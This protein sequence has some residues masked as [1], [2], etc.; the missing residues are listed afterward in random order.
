MNDE[1]VYKRDGKGKEIA[2]QVKAKSLKLRF[3]NRS[4][5]INRMIS[6]GRDEGCEICLADDPLVSRRHALI[7]KEGEHY[8]VMDKGSTNGTYLN[9]NPI[10]KCERVLVASGDVITVGKT[11]LVIQ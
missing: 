7:E 4:I 11:S 1:T 9:G 10:P 2:K 3:K 5:N 6:I 8:Y